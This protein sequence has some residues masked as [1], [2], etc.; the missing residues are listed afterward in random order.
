MLQRNS[1]QDC[2]KSPLLDELPTRC[3]Q[4]RKSLGECKR[5]LVDMRKRFRGNAP[6]SASKELGE[7]GKSASPQLYAGKPAFQSVGGEEVQ[8]EP[9]KTRG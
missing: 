1:P 4:L 8:M 2:L 9:E 3:Q 5:G 6:I 7:G